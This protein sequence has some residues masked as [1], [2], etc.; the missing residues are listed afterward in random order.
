[1]E[2]CQ[3]SFVINITRLKIWSHHSPSPSSLFPL[4]TDGSACPTKRVLLFPCYN[5]GLVH[6]TGVLSHSMG[7]FVCKPWTK[8]DASTVFLYCVKSNFANR[9]WMSL[10]LKKIKN[11]VTS[12]R[13]WNSFSYST[14]VHTA[15]R[16][17]LAVTL[18]TCT[19]SFREK[20]E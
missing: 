11:Y 2:Y 18:P 3:F 4:A 7:V 10:F 13:A 19:L 5:A 8:V 12:R 17:D 20:L 9:I 1:V 14:L 6:W 15:L 16:R